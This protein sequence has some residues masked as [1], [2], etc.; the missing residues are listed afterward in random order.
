M[1]VDVDVD[2]EPEAD[3]L[4]NGCIADQDPDRNFFKREDRTTAIRTKVYKRTVLLL[5]PRYNVR[6]TV[7]DIYDYAC[8]ALRNS[9]TLEPT[10]REEKL[11][12]KLLACCRIRREEYKLPQVVQVLKECADRWNDVQVLLAALK[13]CGVD[14]NIDFMGVEGFVSAYQAFGWDAL[15]EFYET[16]MKND[17]SN[18]RRHALLARL[19]RMAVEEDDA[20]V[21][22]WCK[23]HAE[24]VLRTLSKMDTAQ[25]PWLVDLGLFCG[26]EFL[27]DVILP[28]LQIQ[29]LN[30]TFWIPFV[31]RLQQ[32][33]RGITTTS[34]EVVS[35]LIVQRVS[36]TA[37]NLA[38]FP[39]K[40]SQNGYGSQKNS[41]AILVVIKFCVETNN[42]ALCTDI[43]AK[44]RDAARLGKFDTVF[45]PWLYYAE[46]CPALIQYARSI[47]TAGLDTIFQ[48]F[49]VDVVDSL[50]SA[51]RTTTDGKAITACP[52]TEQHKSTIMIAARKAGGITILKQRLTADK[53][54]GHDSGTLQAL[55]RSVV[56][57]FPRQQMQDSTSLQA[58]SDFIV[59]LV[60]AAIDA[61]TTS[62]LTREALSADSSDQMMVLVKFCFELGAQSQCKHLLLRFVP[63]SAGSTIRQHVSGVLAP[64]LPILR[65]YLLGKD[66]DLQTE[67][68]KT[69]A[70][71]VIKSFAAKVMAQKPGEV[72][73]VAKLQAFGCGACPECG[74]LRAFF[75]E[76]KPMISLARVQSIRAHLERQL[77]ATRAWGVV[78]STIRDRS[79]Y[80]LQVTKPES[81]MGLGLWATNSQTGKKLLNSLGGQATQM[82]ILGA[83]YAWVHARI[84]G[85]SNAN[86]LAPALRM[87]APMP[88]ANT[89]RSLNAPKRPAVAALSAVLVKKA[90]TS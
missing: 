57:E 25:I 3:D 80:S 68:Y 52:L 42:Q 48:P 62:S 49:F 77:G 55:A 74:M 21:S 37:R 44:M 13:T 39:T 58:H 82:R 88:L 76:D 23:E 46:L 69:F 8:N 24:S 40:T 31:R 70:V 45:P 16:A 60:R 36:E 75:M 59:T 38:A 32:S 65:H 86:A 4:I 50:I 22:V 30:K 85:A 5:W 83:D 18:G 26:G 20:E 14:K 6:V 43:F 29:S 19:A 89:T 72:V 87:N 35:G 90:R 63:P 79:P 10:E 73:P 71:E 34:P 53:L 17:L 9:V 41:E 64:F 54:A 78:W 84:Y 67:P 1:P 2:L 61:F 11:V 47:P 27:R 56:K 66:L 81:M 51:A 28:Q 33:M 12:N 15:K 7:G